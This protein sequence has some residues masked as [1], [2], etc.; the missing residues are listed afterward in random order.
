MAALPAAGKSSVK[1]KKPEQKQETPEVITNFNDAPYKVVSDSAHAGNVAAIRAMGYRYYNG[2]EVE[3]NYDRA[4]KFWA[5]A[6]QEGD[7]ESIG[8]LGICYMDGIGVTPDSMKAVKLF[9]KALQLKYDGLLDELDSRSTER[10]LAA[11]YLAQ[12]YSLSG[13][14]NPN[15]EK[16]AKQEMYL[17]RASDAGSLDG[18]RKLGVFLMSTKKYGEALEV[19]TKGAKANDPASLY[20]VGWLCTDPK[21]GQTADPTNALINMRAAADANFPQAQYMLAKWYDSGTNVARDYDMARRYYVAAAGNGN[22]AARWTMGIHY[23]KGDGYPS[24]YNIALNWLTS[25]NPK[26]YVKTFKN[27]FVDTATIVKDTQ[28]YDF[29][30]AIKFL[31]DQKYKDARDIF[32]KLEKA[33]R[34]EAATYIALCDY[35]DPSVKFDEKKLVKA[36]QKAEKKGDPFSKYYLATYYLSKPEFDRD[37]ILT[38]LNNAAEA[39]L[40]QAY[41]KLGE[42]Y[43]EGRVVPADYQTAARHFENAYLHNGLDN[44]SATLYADILE[45]G[46]GGAETDAGKAKMLRELNPDQRVTLFLNAVP[47][48][49]D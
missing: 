3:K 27:L 7:P 37:Q 6:A 2:V 40:G 9:D 42:I 1:S 33:K 16:R 4:A 48:A 49:L 5:K 12:R 22:D 45:N 34:P 25:T 18:T 17:Q 31:K 23:A 35:A 26:V 20:Y 38:L 44:H 15:A 47:T 10:P 24:D 13:V 29:V 8:R 32:K 43:A 14:P 21:F 19:F 46:R 39:G 11:L 30:Q 28:L 36:L 41:S